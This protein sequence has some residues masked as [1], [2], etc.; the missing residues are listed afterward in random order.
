MAELTLLQ[1]IARGEEG[2]FEECVATYDGL[3]KAMAGSWFSKTNE[4]EDL[5]Q[6]VYVELWLSA[7]RFD[8]NVSAEASFVKMITRRQMINRL[9]RNSRRSDVPITEG[10][11]FH[12]SD[13]VDIEQNLD[14]GRV[15]QLMSDFRPEQRKVLSLFFNLGMSHG[16]ISETM[17]M[18]LGTVKSHIRR[19]VMT[20][21]EQTLRGSRALSA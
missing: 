16:E 17:R 7:A 3:I 9:R 8:P 10:M 14:A 5:A 11:D 2:A 6:D 12:D 15:A 4:S 20:M 13:S 1:R 21:R 19:G 18:A